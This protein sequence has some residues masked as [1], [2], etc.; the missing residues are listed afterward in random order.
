MSGKK[1]VM[2]IDGHALAYRA[3]HAIPPLT[4]ASGEPTNATFGFANMLLKAIQDHTPDCVIT[5]FDVGLTFRHEAYDDYKATRPPTPDDLRVQVERIKE[6]LAAMGIPIYTKE[7]YEA[8]DVL[9]T[10]AH[11]ASQ[12]GFETIIVTGDTDTF[13]LVSPDVLVLAPSGR[14]NEP[15]LYSV[16][17]IRERYGLEPQQLIDYKALK[18]DPSDNIPGVAGIGDK[19][20]TNLLKQYSSVEAI[21]EHLAELPKGRFRTALEQGR[22]EAF[23]S[24]RLVR[25]VCDVPGIDLDLAHC[26]WS[27]FDHETVAALLRELGF[28]SLVDRM[29]HFRT[30]VG[31]QLGLFSDHTETNGEQHRDA[32][33]GEYSV[34][35]T[36][37]ALDLLVKQLRGVEHFAL[38]T[39]TTSTDSMRAD[40]VGISLADTPGRAYYIP[41]GHDQRLPVGQQLPLEVVRAKLGPV[42]ADAHVGKV[43]HNAIFDMVV[44]AEHGMPTEGLVFD[45]MIAA[46]LLEPGGRGIGLKNQAWQQLG[47]EMTPIEDL[48][49]KG[50]KKT[51]MDQLPVAKVAPYSCADADMTLRLVEKLQPALEERAQWDLFS[52]VEVPLVPVL[53]DMERH[54]MKVDASYLEVMSRELARRLAELSG[55]VFNLAGH[56]FNINSPKQLG[57]VLFNELNLPVVRRTQTGYSTDAAVMEELAPKHPIVPLILEYRQVEKLKGTYVDALPDLINPHTGR[58]HTSFNQTGTSTGRLSSSEPNLQNIPVRTELGRL[59][60]GAF[61]APEGRVLL[62]CDYSQVELRL[63][64]HFSQ[65]PELLGAFRRDEDVHAATAS[66]IFGVPLDQV[67]PQQRGLAKTINFALMYGIS[68]YGLSTRTDLSVGEAREFIQA[69]FDRFKGVK[70]YL[71]SIKA[72]AY[73]NGYV[74]T[75]LGRRRYFPELRSRSVAGQ[76]QAAERAAI[77]M[78]IQGT[79]ADIVK[80]AMIHLHRRLA[81][82]RLAGTMLLQVHDELV[83]EVPKDELHDTQELVVHTMENACQLSVPLKVEARVG[84][85]WMEM[86]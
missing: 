19:T 54:G 5:A 48:I 82:R 85:N 35:D 8:D 6:L 42:L 65:D 68:D 70:D 34:V 32:S 74:T 61:V 43:M 11:Q 28:R 81:E 80:L 79:A 41:I 69:Y 7:G 66:A 16:D 53:V 52:E 13:Q 77:N 71:E 76:R 37:E 29:M 14:F 18:G 44:L 10:L 20:A 31:S 56:P 27:E 17:A 49:G 25:I 47:I 2:L 46:W 21:Y 22:E 72:F 57:E 58:V 1:R 30:A 39:E 55:E 15:I 78:P 23:M 3:Y 59:V 67:T 50:R 63:L 45:T 38:D 4:N 84:S 40:L 62:S 12:L 86:E 26:E 83:L 73:E 75:L 36:L 64:A 60:R 24:K 9:G 33:L 51:S